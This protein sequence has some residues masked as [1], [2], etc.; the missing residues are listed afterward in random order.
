MSLLNELKIKYKLSAIHEK[1]IFVNVGIFAIIAI[2][3]ALFFFGT[4]G[5]LTLFSEYLALSESLGKL[6]VR[7]WTIIS[8]NFLHFTFWHLL[9]NMIGLYF[10]GRIFLTFYSAKQFI[11]YYFLGGIFAGLLFV[12]AYNVLPALVNDN[13][14]LYGASAAVFAILLGATTRAPN[15]ELNLFGVFKLRLWVF[16]TLYIISS[17]A[18]IPNTNTGGELA[19]LGG[20]LLGYIYTKQLDKGNNI[21]AGFERLYDWVSRFFNNTKS[22]NLKTVHKSKT[23]VGGYT[24]GEFNQFN[25]QKQVDLILDKISKSGYDSLTAAEKEFLFKAGK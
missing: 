8:Y 22:K 2:L 6:V 21:G 20:A 15:Y 7:F 9:G 19:H 10:F 12:I 23:K 11:S 16:A 17:I 3:N 4:K 25:N 13:A 18:L 5:Q 14:I 24:K 1:F